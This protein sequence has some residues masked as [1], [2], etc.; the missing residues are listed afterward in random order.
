MRGT[1]CLIELGMATAVAWD[2][3]HTF[4]KSECGVMPQLPA[5]FLMKAVDF[6]AARVGLNMYEHIRGARL[7]VC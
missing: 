1:V 3:E 6:L 7:C 5:Y 2:E 4:A